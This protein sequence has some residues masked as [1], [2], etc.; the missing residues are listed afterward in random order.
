MQAGRSTDGEELMRRAWLNG[1]LVDTCPRLDNGP[2]GLPKTQLI[3]FTRHVQVH[4]LP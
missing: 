3:N 4:V 1:V 2:N